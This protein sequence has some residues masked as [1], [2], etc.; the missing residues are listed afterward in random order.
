MAVRDPAFAQ[1]IGRKFNRITITV[2]HLDAVASESPG[3]CRQHR[4]TWVNLDSKQ[5][6]L[7]LLET[8]PITSMASSFGKSVFDPPLCAR[9][10]LPAVVLA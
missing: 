5:P 4:F 10:G 2:H 1:V 9:S 8:T 6:R 3:H 7:E